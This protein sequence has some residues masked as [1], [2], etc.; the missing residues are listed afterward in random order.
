MYKKVKLQKG[1]KVICKN[2]W[3]AL[4]DNVMVLNINLKFCLIKMSFISEN[5]SRFKNFF[6]TKVKDG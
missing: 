2:S 6:Y 3:F 4:K 1:N 5:N